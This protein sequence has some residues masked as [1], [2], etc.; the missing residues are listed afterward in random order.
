MELI[1]LQCNNKL[2]HIFGT[3]K[4]KIDFMTH[5]SQKKQLS[6]YRNLVQKVVSA[7]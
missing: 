6:D 2:Q 7:F 5:K 4:S 3:L 1:Y